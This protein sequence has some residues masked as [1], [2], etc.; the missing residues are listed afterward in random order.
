MEKDRA[1]LD[2]TRKLFRVFIEGLEAGVEPQPGGKQTLKTMALT[3][4]CL[5][6]SQTG[7]KIEMADFYRRYG[8]APKELLD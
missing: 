2:D 6:S 5:E 8:V 3:C 7:E 4:A 1:F